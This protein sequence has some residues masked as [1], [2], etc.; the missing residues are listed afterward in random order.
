MDDKDRQLLVFLRRGIPL[1]SRPFEEISRRTGIDGADILL[2]LARLKERKITGILT[3]I[4]DAKHLGYQSVLA[5]MQF[6]EDELGFEFAALK[7]SGH[8]G[9]V[10]SHRRFH[11]FNFWFTLMLPVTESFEE[12][13]KHLCRIS[14]GA[15]A[16]TFPVI[17]YFRAGTMITNESQ[18]P[19]QIF[20]TEEIAVLRALQEEMPLT[21]EPFRRLAK[22]CGLGEAEF[23]AIAKKFEKQ[24]I[25]KR[26]AVLFPAE[27][28]PAPPQDMT[29]W[30]VPEE[31]QDWAAAK[32]SAAPE[33]AQC[34]RR[35]AWPEFPY[36]LHA[37]YGPG[38]D[39]EKTG[40]EL[41]E[42]IGKW[43]RVNLPV[44]AVYKNERP[45]YFPKELEKWS[46]KNEMEPANF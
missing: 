10:R 7:V 34:S 14:K 43:P 2:R 12:H 41:E 5:A 36:G 4:L 38:A 39:P 19:Y 28:Q 31:K 30:Q 17:K 26:F 35:T 8:P 24:G 45:R 44:V 21:D 33:V 15:A 13:L 46:R 42:E 3:G 29:V 32:I 23:L 9:V 1:C 16:L 22:E 25:L 40:G 11:A 20:S 6:P 18:R 37:A 27:E